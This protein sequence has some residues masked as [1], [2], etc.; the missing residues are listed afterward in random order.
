MDYLKSKL[1]V[2]INALLDEYNLNDK[3]G[4]QIKPIW[5]NTESRKDYREFV[6]VF[7]DIWNEKL[8]LKLPSQEA[9]DYEPPLKLSFFDQ[10]VL[11]TTGLKFVSTLVHANLLRIL[12][13]KNLFQQSAW[14]PVELNDNKILYLYKLSEDETE[15]S[16]FWID[17]L[18]SESPAPQT[19]VDIIPEKIHVDAQK[20]FNN[21]LAKAKDALPILKAVICCNNETLLGTLRSVLIDNL[22]KNPNLLKSLSPKSLG[23]FIF[24]MAKNGYWGSVKKVLL[25]IETFNKKL[26]NTDEIKVDFNYTSCETTGDYFLHLAARIHNMEIVK[27]AFEFGASPLFVNKAKQK[28]ADLDPTQAR[29]IA[30]ELENREQE[31]SAMQCGLAAAQNADQN[32]WKHVQTILQRKEVDVNQ[33]SH[34]THRTVFHSAAAAMSDSKMAIEIYKKGG[35]IDLVGGF[36]KKTAIEY[37]IDNLSVT[38][39][40]GIQATEFLTHIILDQPGELPKQS[41]WEKQINDIHV[42][43]VYI[44]LHI[45]KNKW[46]IFSQLFSKVRSLQLDFTLTI[47]EPPYASLF[48]IAC[49]AFSPAVMRNFVLSDPELVKTLKGSQ[50]GDLISDWLIVP[51]FTNMDLILNFL[52]KLPHP[53]Y[54]HKNSLD[55]KSD[56]VKNTVFDKLGLILVE[57]K[58]FPHLLK[59]L[60]FH[61]VKIDYAM[62]NVSG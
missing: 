49:D 42:M 29:T 14:I 11:E 2:R 18:A 26:E 39:N 31:L 6:E 5:K 19:F 25:L 48:A 37:A 4:T 61:P 47:Q 54:G 53:I 23:K 34:I 62:K 27:T 57:S 28:P 43:F 15:V 32:D 7:T 9:K 55:D 41:M 58:K 59:L 17:D 16:L 12:H 10:A 52:E 30:H 1:I 20:E 50:I 44:I 24:V 13:K 8:K 3:N 60:E 40:G 33:F 35:R 45:E 46:D 56:N 51:D 36:A 38:R 22:E 21:L